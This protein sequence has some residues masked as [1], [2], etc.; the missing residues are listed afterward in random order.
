M[1]KMWTGSS[2]YLTRNKNL[3]NYIHSTKRPFL[4]IFCFYNKLKDKINCF[5]L[6]ENHPVLSLHAGKFALYV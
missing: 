4:I 3:H 5:P 1:L 6:L 2:H